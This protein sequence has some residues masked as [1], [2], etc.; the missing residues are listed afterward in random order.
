MQQGNYQYEIENGAAVITAYM[1]GEEEQIRIPSRFGQVAVTA[2][3]EEAFAE[4]GTFLTKIE[5]PPCVKEIRAGAF[6]MCMCLETLV[7]HEGLET[8]GAEAFYLTPLGE[9]YLPA[10]VCL[11]ERAWELSAIR[12]RVAPANPW[13]YTEGPGLYRDGVLL[14]V[15]QGEESG[16]WD[17]PPVRSEGIPGT[18]SASGRCASGKTVVVGEEVPEDIRETVVGVSGLG[19]AVDSKEGIMQG[20]AK[21]AAWMPG[22][23]S[24]TATGNGVAESN[25]KA[26]AGQS[27]IQAAADMG[28]EVSGPGQGSTSLYIAPGTVEIGESACSGNSRIRELL[29]PDSLR[30]IGSAAFE[31]CQNLEKVRLAE[32]L[33]EIRENAFGH[34]ISLHTLHLPATLE[35]LGH[36]AISDTFGWSDS[37]SG[38]KSITVEA[39]NRFFEADGN[40]LYERSIPAAAAGELASGCRGAAC[41][42]S[43]QKDCC[44]GKTFEPGASNASNKNNCPVVAQ[45]LIHPEDRNTQSGRMPS[46]GGR[47]MIKYF[48]KQSTFRVPEDITRILPSAFRRASVV[49]LELPASVRSVG[50]DAFRECRNLEEI[51]LEETGAT[52]YVPRSPVYRKD[53]ITAL[54]YDEKRKE[55]P[56]EEYENLPEQ[57]QEFVPHSYVSLLGEARREN[58]QDYIFDYRGYDALFSTYLNTADLCG[59]ACCRLTFP[60]LLSTAV[61][62]VYEE[63]LSSHVS[64]IINSLAESEDAKTLSALAGLGFF[65]EET[66]DTAIEVL[67]AAGRTGMV[68]WMLGWQAANLQ[69]D[70]F[71]FEL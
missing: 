52:L 25:S 42:T 68:S 47:T 54:L 67:D 53:E 61:R 29:L 60:V 16:S 50:K 34:C 5:V 38:I 58:R 13:F 11:L 24:I 48:G 31:G 56:P 41:S 6:R 55:L 1:G 18:A 2:I 9:L 71:D 70:E 37:L 8:I 10:S 12:F 44:V 62:A 28:S 3:G 69:A 17:E 39:G 33:R 32:G 19:I 66:I 51:V 65:T 63:F 46:S 30:V 45:N 26:A 15:Y 21:T 43:V 4:N 49:R 64:E 59:M 27:G 22:T 23:Q 36:H 20:D 14:V 40:A 7:L 35:K 57:W